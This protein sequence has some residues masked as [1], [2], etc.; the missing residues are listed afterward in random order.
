MPV[1]SEISVPVWYRGGKICVRRDALN[2][3][4]P[5][6]TY[7]YV[8]RT[9]GVDPTEYGIEAPLDRARILIAAARAGTIELRA[10]QT[11][12]PP[13]K[14][15]ALAPAGIPGEGSMPFSPPPSSMSVAPEK[16]EIE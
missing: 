8:L 6:S 3:E 12:S 7:N 10:S 11:V 1:L 13:V 2:P 14:Q 9:Y 15:D 5:E 16:G 4:H